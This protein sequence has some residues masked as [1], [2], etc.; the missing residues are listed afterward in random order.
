MKKPK[1]RYEESTLNFRVPNELKFTIANKAQEMNITVSKYLRKLLEE[2][3]DGTLVRQDIKVKERPAF[4]S[5]IE[6]LKLMVWIYQKRQDNK[7][8]ESEEEL[9]G[10]VRTL[11]RLDGHLPDEIVREFDKVLTNVIS[12]KKNEKYYTESFAF[13]NPYSSD[14]KFD[15][16]MVERYLLSL[17]KEN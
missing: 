2:V 14:N 8:M 17:E 13:S 12:I 16:G 9:A 5:S 3:H 7:L 1:K 15:Y 10:Y 4:L 6:F 11:K